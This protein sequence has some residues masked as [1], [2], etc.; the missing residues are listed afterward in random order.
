M[1]RR[2]AGVSPPGTYMSIVSTAKM[3]ARQFLQLGEDPPGVR[4]ELVDGEIAVA[5]SSTPDHSYTESVLSWLIGQHLVAGD[6]GQLFGGVNTILGPFDVRRPDLIFFS[7]ERL[8]LVG[9][10]AMEGP[11][12]LCVEIISP[13]SETIDRADKFDQYAKAGVAFYWIIDPRP[14]TLEAY[15]LVGS[16]YQL[17]ASGRDAD[18]LRLP[19]FEKIEIPL[20]K[21]W[22]PKL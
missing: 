10:K 2:R 17:V 11:P 19:P 22:R 13:S 21:L 16:E 12:D 8:H 6:W 9:D 20:G 1:H 15:R 14:R 7:K 5:P 3:N 18:V 4:L